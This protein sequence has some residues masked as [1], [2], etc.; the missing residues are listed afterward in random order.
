[1][2]DDII[3]LLDLKDE[4]LIVEGP[5]ISKGVKLLTLSKKLTPRFC[6]VCGC[7]MHSKGIY[8]RT[9]NHPVLQDGTRLLLKLRQR[10]WK[11]IN[12]LCAHTCNDT[13]S[14]VDPR[15]R[16]TNLADLSIVLAFKDPQL[17]ASQITKRFSVSDTYA[18]SLFAR[19]VQIPRRQLPQAL[20]I[21][22]VHVDISH[23]CNYAMILQDF[24]TGGP[25][26][27]IA[28][29]RKEITEPYFLSI[30]FAER[31]Q[32][33]YLIS[34][35]YRPYTAYVDQYFP[36]AVS[37]VDSFHVIKMINDKI[38]RYI[39]KL[40]AQYRRLDEKRHEDLEQ[41]LGRHIEFTSSKEY[42]LLKHFKWLI[43]K[44]ADDI[45]Y[46]GKPRYNYKLKRYITLGE[47]EKMLFDID[48]DLQKI[49][50][51]KERYILFNRRYEDNYKSARVALKELFRLYYDCPYTL[52]HEAADT[53]SYHFDS[54]CNSFIMIQR[55]NADGLHLSRLSN[56]PME[57]LNRIAKDLK[58]N[59]HG[60]R[61]FEHLRNRFLFSQRK[62]ASILAV[63]KAFED[64][65]P[66]T[67]ITRGPY[68]KKE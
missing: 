24:E 6:P 46:S 14:F 4:D 58:R 19:Y 10:R 44:N 65:C 56:G 28:N 11:C 25:V 15:R 52:F 8:P 7:K 55:M 22:E 67:D 61:N 53:L 45:A 48:P 38:L 66:K 39:R 16:N 34:D 12:P 54:I 32:V 68:K 21:D 23:V 42:Y 41:Q 64:A 20:C 18:I 26:D 51:L 57:S 37:I 62:N 13:F 59:G 29:Q 47:I 30:S 43:L 40:Q 17:S 36:N 63:P 27:M 5:V 33:K 31:K 2:S 60:Y 49:R 3:K 1:M 9:V 50:N 35:M